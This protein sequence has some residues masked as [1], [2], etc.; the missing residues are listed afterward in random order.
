V[1]WLN[2]RQI[3]SISVILQDFE[4]EV[5]GMRGYPRDIVRIIE[6][7]RIGEGRGEYPPKHRLMRLLDFH[8]VRP[9]SDNLNMN[10][11]T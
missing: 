8:V 2:R 9:F 3:V 7:T 1:S 10:N 6:I 11:S 5:S 4:E